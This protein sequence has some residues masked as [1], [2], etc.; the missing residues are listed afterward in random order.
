MKTQVVTAM[1]RRIFDEYGKDMVR[2]FHEMWP[3]D[4]TLHLYYE[5]ESDFDQ[6]RL[7]KQVAAISPRVVVY[8]QLGRDSDL[9]DFINR[10][11]D[12]PDQQNPKELHKGAI[13]FSYKTFAI[14]NHC[15]N[16]PRLG[17]DRVVWLD[18]DTVTYKKIPLN[19][20]E[21]LSHPNVYV[22]YLGRDDN[23]PECGFVIYNTANPINLLFMGI[24]E[25]LYTSDNVFRLE[26]WHD[27]FVFD[28]IRR[29]LLEDSQCRNLT[30]YGSGY[31]HVF[32]NSEVGKYID[33]FKGDRKDKKKSRVSDIMDKH[34]SDEMRKRLSE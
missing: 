2:S 15:M 13:R 8:D 28:S 32:V 14:I 31:D 19:W 22:T 6:D 9:V 11:K 4:I 24:W 26:Q 30:P 20:I 33:H 1:N 23:Y 10:N 25:A 29:D 16:A 3:D 7:E 5:K 17:V 27:S 34:V 18:A 12:R 21:L